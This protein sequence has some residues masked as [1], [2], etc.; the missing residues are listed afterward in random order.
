M[1][2][3]AGMTHAL[4]ALR[5][6]D[7]WWAAV[8]A[9]CGV[10]LYLWRVPLAAGTSAKSFTA[11][12]SG[13][14]ALTML[15]WVC[16]LIGFAGFA[17]LSLALILTDM[18]TLRLPNRLL[19]FAAVWLAVWL[20]PS[21]LNDPAWN[22]RYGW[23][24]MN[25]AMFAAMFAG[26]WLRWRHS[27]GGGDVKLAPLCG[28]A[29]AWIDLGGVLIFFIALILACVLPII[30]ALR[31]PQRQIPFGPSM[32]AASWSAIAVPFDAVL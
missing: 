18:R 7:S 31:A 20:A 16:G 24:V 15:P 4:A 11:P 6:R 17:V 14:D 27:F 26:M 23:A 21:L 12:S 32:L 10:V 13:Y 19:L 25:A 22:G 29:V 5:P 28:F 1:A 2:V 30:V 8:A 9:L 3:G